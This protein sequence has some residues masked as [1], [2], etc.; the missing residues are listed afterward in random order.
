MLIGIMTFWETKGYFYFDIT[1][2]QGHITKYSLERDIIWSTNEE[3]TSKS[4]KSSTVGK[5]SASSNFVRV[6]ITT[7]PDECWEGRHNDSTG[8]DECDYSNGRWNETCETVWIS[9]GGL[10]PQDNPNYEGVGGGGSTPNKSKCTN[11]SGT[12]IVNSQPISGISPIAFLTT[13]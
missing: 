12:R 13:L 3:F 4:S 8:W 5:T 1:S 10:Y 2:F 6:C 11:T 7:A 9:G